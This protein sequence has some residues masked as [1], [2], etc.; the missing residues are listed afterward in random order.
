MT[1]R[2]RNMKNK[3]L[4][5]KHENQNGEHKESRKEEKRVGA[6]IAT[7][8]IPIIVSC[9]ALIVSVISIWVNFY[10]NNKEY[11]YK[12]DPEIEVTGR[13]GL[14]IHQNG[15]GYSEETFLDDM[16]IH[17]LQKNN[18]Q[19]AYLIYPGSTVEKLVIADMEE[20]LMSKFNQELKMNKAD[21]VF[22]NV[23][24]QYL[25]LLLKGMDDT[26]ELYL[27]YAKSNG[28]VFGFQGASGIEIWGLANSHPNNPDFEG[29]KV[30][31]AQYEQII[32]ESGKYIF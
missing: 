24:Y 7:D 8:I 16:Q 21:L 3:A 18:L 27:V 25:F 28:E 13:I 12:I 1:N 26:S 10:Y 14:Q 31:A 5:K 2:N 29:E 23:T 30:M 6:Q 19:E 22:G 4:T 9:L 11:E 32:K 20:K 15:N 17:I